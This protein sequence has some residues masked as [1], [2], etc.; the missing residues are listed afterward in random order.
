MRTGCLESVKRYTRHLLNLKEAASGDRIMNVI[1][2]LYQ[3]CK[4]QENHF[5]VISQVFVIDHKSKLVAR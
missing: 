5:K 4:C 2:D 1:S 3:L